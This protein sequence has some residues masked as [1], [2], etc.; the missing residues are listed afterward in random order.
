[1]GDHSSAELTLL[2]VCLQ[3][4]RLAAAAAHV[5]NG[6]DNEDVLGI[7]LKTTGLCGGSEGHWT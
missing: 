7:I 6:P 4:S 2:T 3:L 1:M 5:V